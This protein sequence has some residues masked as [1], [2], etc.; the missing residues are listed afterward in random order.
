M[1][2][3]TRTNGASRIVFALTALMAV[4]AAGSAQG[5]LPPARQL[6]DRYI[7]AIG[8]AEA[9]RSHQ[10]MHLTGTFSMASM[11]MSGKM[12]TFQVKPDRTYTKVTIDGVGEMLQGY[13]GKVAW[14][15]NP[16]EGARILEEAELA[17]V[18]D[19]ADF[20][21]S[22][23]RDPSLVA[24][25]ETVE[26][27]DIGGKTCYKVKVTWKSGRESYDCYDTNTGLIVAVVR[28]AES[29]MG[30]IEVTTLLS[31]HKAF[32]GVT[33]P[34]RMTQQ[35]MGQEQVITIESVDFGKIDPAVFVLP[36]EV[37]ALVKN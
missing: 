18:K 3:N 33:V 37:K 27:T 23:M 13:D 24:S 5:A 2:R 26:R 21:A 19:E 36:P 14:S 4:P 32:D 20:T 16:M 15:V 10:A 25:M 28:T 11:G 6:V 30:Q 31:N 12:E 9:I 34:T 17:Q 35:M 8:G 29:P 7:K 1:I 22:Q